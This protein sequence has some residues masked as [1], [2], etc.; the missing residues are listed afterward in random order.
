MSYERAYRTPLL[1]GF[2]SEGNRLP[3][4][5]TEYET[6]DGRGCFGYHFEYDRGRSR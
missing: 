3:L 5:H 2:S 4:T 6:P 1:P